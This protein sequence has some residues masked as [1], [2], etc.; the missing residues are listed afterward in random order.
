MKRIA[1]LTSGGDAPG[2]NAAIRA[3]VRASVF[4]NAEIFAIYDGYAGLIEN[5]FEQFNVRSVSMILGRGGTILKSSR[6][7]AFRTV[8]GRELAFKHLKTHGIDGLVVIGGDGSL[9]GAHKLYQEF[10]FPVMGIPAT[11]D[12]DLAY[13]DYTIGFDTSTNVVTQSV[14]KIRDTASSH[15][16]LF[17][18]EVM[19]RNTGFIALRA[20]IASGALC[21]MLPER[22]VGVEELIAILRKAHRNKK[23]SSIVLVAEGDTN[24]DA[25][26]LAKKVTMNYADYETKVTV[27]GHLQRGGSPTC[28]D[29]VLASE[30]GI[31][32]V[33]GWLEGKRDMMVGMIR[34]SVQ[35]TPL[36][37]VLSKRKDVN[38]SL[39]KA[40]QI[41]SI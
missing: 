4:Y 18:V 7:E 11:I 30:L 8:E 21:I 14:D 34:E 10:N 12:N 16:R 33:E 31:S 6:S 38:Q 41:L 37:E 2:M 17:F 23:T 27:L 40:A 1:L 3:V 24:G 29:R 22:P 35:F 28:F 15:N 19:G 9:T 36:E 39:I 26:E 13:T 25:Y 20:G 32:A 5:K